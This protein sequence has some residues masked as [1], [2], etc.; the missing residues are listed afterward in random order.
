MVFILNVPLELSLFTF[1]Y[2]NDTNLLFLIIYSYFERLFL[3]CELYFYY[4]SSN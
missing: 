4:S 1:C 3:A 2:Y